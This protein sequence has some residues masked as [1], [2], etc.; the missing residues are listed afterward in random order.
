MEQIDLS[1]SP[2]LIL[3]GL[4]SLAFFI[5]IIY[6]LVLFIRLPLFRATHSPTS[7]PPV[8]VVICA[9][10]EEDNLK[11]FLPLVLEQDYPVYEVVLVNDCSLDRSIDVLKELASRY[12]NLKVADIKEVEGREHGKKF[13]MTIG[14]KAAK[15]EHLLFTDADCY[16][17]SKNWMRLIIEGY[18]PEK[19]I[20][21]GYGKYA[22]YPGFVNMMIR[23]DTFFIAV[24]YLSM[25][26]A[27]KAYMGVGRN[28]AYLKSLFFQ[29]KGFASHMHINSGDDDLFVN[30]AA[31]PTNTEIIV[32]KEAFTISE[33]KKTWRE[34]FL[35]K[36]RHHST[37][38]HYKINHKL[39]LAFYP[40]SWYIFHFSLIIGLAINYNLPILIFSFIL[41]G[42]IQ[43]IILQSC[44]RKL[45][46]SGM[47]WNA[48]FLEFIYR[49]F[50]LPVYFFST[51]FVR[52]RKWN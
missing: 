49:F 40:F 4:F 45:D 11:K 18:K 21:L 12:K 42:I 1:L 28:M 3:L 19:E 29:H 20:I 48:P 50:V 7:L 22:R 43:I 34:W 6:Y 24:Q 47:G 51:L 32:S 2:W 38:H 27:G 15:Y 31:T 33:P 35:Q 26:I 5:Q 37:A 14:I 52:Q 8:S 13:A 44:A 23:F 10:N 41:R 36:K 16:P 46:E 9:R 25:A 30:Q 17:V 39:I